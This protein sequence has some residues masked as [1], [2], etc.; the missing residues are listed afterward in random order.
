MN[1]ALW[2]V[3]GLLAFAMLTA[4]GIKV[5]VPRTKLMEKMKWAKTWS[6]GEFK[7]LGLA[8][9]LGGIGVIVPHATRIVPVLTPVAAVCLVVLMLGA[10]KTHVD[11]KE[12]PAAPAI[13][14]LLGVFVA[15]GRFGIL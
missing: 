8:E 6:D 10:V 5:A 15:L 4:G 3:S 11:L 13:L 12:S 9:V 7:L 1:I 14:A 2:I